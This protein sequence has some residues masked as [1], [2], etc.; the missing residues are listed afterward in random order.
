MDLL[1]GPTFTIDV[2]SSSPPLYTSQPSQTQYA[3][4]SADSSQSSSSIGTPDDTDDENDAV[5]SQRNQ[6]NSEHDND[7]DEQEEQVHKTLKNLASLDSLED[8]LPIK[9]GLSNHFMGKSKSFTDLSQVNT[10]K[11]LQ[12]QENPFNKRRRVQIASKWSRRSSFYTWANPK[13][14]PLLPLLEDQHFYQDNPKK[15]SPS[16]SLQK[17]HQDQVTE[18]HQ[19]QP[20]S[21]VDH[22]RHKFGSFKSRSLS[23]LK[24]H[25]DDE[26]ED[27]D[28]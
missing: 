27:D 14:M 19:R 7:D 20:K 9:R 4:F 21:Y 22:M 16:S 13:S 2:S 24:E 1:L 12:K 10:V 17:K 23:D 18:T 11:E 5:S 3:R 8:S 25:D 6:N 26:E 28:D 15:L